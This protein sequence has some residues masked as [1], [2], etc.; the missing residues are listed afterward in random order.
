MSSPEDTAAAPAAL[1]PGGC[2]LSPPFIPM[3]PE[4]TDKVFFCPH[5]CFQTILPQA[6]QLRVSVFRPHPLLCS[7]LKPSTDPSSLHALKIFSFWLILAPWEKLLW[8]SLSVI[9]TSTRM[10]LPRGSSLT[11]WGSL[12]FNL[13]VTENHLHDCNG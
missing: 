8:S 13:R 11:C 6:L 7:L 1:S 10:I 2:F 9:S 5:C 3:A 12:R 4:V